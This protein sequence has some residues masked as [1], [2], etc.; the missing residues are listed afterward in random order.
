MKSLNNSSVDVGGAGAGVGSRLDIGSGPSVGAGD[1]GV[2]ELD[3]LA[4]LGVPSVGGAGGSV[5]H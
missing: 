4:A 5:R 3:K 2:N 1:P